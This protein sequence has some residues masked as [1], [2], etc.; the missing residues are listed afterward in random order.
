M[1][2]TM[3]AL[4]DFEGQGVDRSAIRITKAGDGLSAALEFQPVA[5]HLGQRVYFVL[6]GEVAQI[7]HKPDSKDDV[8]V[9][10]HTIE[11]V[12]ITMVEAD[13]VASM[14]DEAA[15]RVRAW[16]A[17]QEAERERI[18]AEEEQAAR[19]A[20]ER[21]A[22]IMRLDDAG[23][24]DGEAAEPDVPAPAEDELKKARKRRAAAGDS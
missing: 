14:L 1:T 15:E 9:R 16:Q 8:L 23:D 19:L 21:E 3:V 6:A 13:A 2:D 24:P 22:G 20:E 5:L 11:V 4:P 12:D 10:L 7:N 18:L 17:E